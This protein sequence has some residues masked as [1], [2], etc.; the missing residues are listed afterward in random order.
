MLIRAKSLLQ[1]TSWVLTD[2]A[3]DFA[4]RPYRNAGYDEHS[5]MV[6]VF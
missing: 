5:Y 2:S 4:K 6:I 1:T 3:F